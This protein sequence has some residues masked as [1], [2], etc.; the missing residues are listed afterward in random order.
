MK[1]VNRSAVTIRPKQPYLDWANSLPGPLTGVT[2]DQLRDDCP[3]YLVPQFPDNEKALAW[4]NQR[5]DDFFTYELW[6]WST[7]EKDWPRKRTVKMFHEWFDV[8]IDSEVIDIG[9][10]EIEVEEDT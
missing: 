9:S 5:F 3:V 10:G 1:S 7:E 2:L 4:V 6:G 8:T